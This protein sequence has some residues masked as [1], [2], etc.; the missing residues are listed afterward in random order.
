MRENDEKINPLAVLTPSFFLLL[1]LIGM[2][3]IQSGCTKNTDDDD[4]DVVGNWVRRSEFEGYGRTEAVSFTIGNRVYVGGGYDGNERLADFW[5]FDEPTGTWLQKAPF[6]GTP[7]NSAVAFS[8]NGK[9]YIGTGY[10]ENDN[11][12]KDFWEYDP[13][14]DVWTRKADFGGTAR[15]NAVGFSISGKGYIGTG[16]D[17]N[18][19]KDLW[20]YTPGITSIDPGTWTQKASLTGSKRTEA[21]VFVYNNLAYIVG[22]FNNGTYVNDFWVYNPVSNSWTEKRKISTVNSDEDYDDDYGENIRR[23]NAVA[24]VMGNKAFLTCGT[25]SGVTGTTWA[26][27]IDNDTWVQKTSLEGSAREGALGFTVNGKGFIVTGSNS[28]YYFDDL[29]E[30]LPDAEQ[31]DNDN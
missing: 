8:I 27:N 5:E 6:P 25:M 22:G 7:R 21:V 3:T 1:L 24:F 28:S 4:D 20:E 11:K 15:Y 23:G 19:L 26:Y 31:D 17:G 10:D 30:F 9:G 12:L 14:T 2:I 16:Y 29:W 18:Y 13:A